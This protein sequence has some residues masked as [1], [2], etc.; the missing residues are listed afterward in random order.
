MKQAQGCR[1]IYR[2]ISLDFNIT[3]APNFKTQAQEDIL[4]YLVSLLDKL[5]IIF[6]LKTYQKARPQII[7]PDNASLVRSG[8]R[9]QK[10]G[11]HGPRYQDHLAIAAK[12]IY[13]LKYYI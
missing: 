9:T 11:R 1:F 12:T 5:I 13:G 3:N 2:V 7:A 8:L 4:N 10:S 6:V